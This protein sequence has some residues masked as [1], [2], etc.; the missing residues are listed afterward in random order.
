MKRHIRNT[1]FAIFVLLFITLGGY[2][3]LH[4]QG[5]VVDFKELKIEK[6]GAIFLKFTPRDATL[7]IDGEETEYAQ[8]GFL[9][10]SGVIIKNLAPGSYHLKLAKSEYHDWGKNLEVQSGIITSAGQIR[11][12]PKKLPGETLKSE[13]V[14]NFWLTGGGIVY[15]NNDAEITFDD[16]II[17]GNQVFL[18]ETRSKLLIT[19]EEKDYFLI[20]LENPFSAVNLT[21]F[22]NSLKQRQLNLPGI[23]PVK[24]VFF[25]PFSPNKLIITS[26]TSL[27]TID[28]KKVQIEKL[29][30]LEKIK[31]AEIS[32]NDAFII[33]ENDN[34]VIINLLLKTSLGGT[35][36]LGPVKDF[37]VDSDGTNVFILTPEDEL[38]VHNRSSGKTGIFTT[39]V[40]EFA[41]SPE[42]KRVAIVTTDDKI[43]VIYVEEF[44]GDLKHE[45]GTITEIPASFQGNVK[46]LEWL[47]AFP[48]Y[49][50]FLEDNNL[51][52]QEIDSRIPANS[53]LFL[54]KVIDYRIDDEKL[55]I[56]KENGELTV[57]SIAASS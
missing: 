10:S 17:R 50:M 51:I 22:F 38:K 15:E 28:A 43:E 37:R 53:H 18:S 23:I 35:T 24:D 5:F 12:W 56:L 1:L 13:G 49:V 16:F 57:F 34:L 32:A 54:N 9:E 55:Y 29:V 6:T 31:S 47:V 39:D 46:K 11:L 21:H 27:Y 33:D 44:K 8:S 20:D 14:K 7:F 25:H 3:I 36:E 26:G 42:E 2:L 48:N 45:A 41:V 30:T 40:G 4:A 19:K 52:V